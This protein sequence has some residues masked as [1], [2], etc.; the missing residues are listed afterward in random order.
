MVNKLGLFDI[1]AQGM[2]REK[3]VEFDSNAHT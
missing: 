1:A 2:T 3:K